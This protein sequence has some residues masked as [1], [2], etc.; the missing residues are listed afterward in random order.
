MAKP[1]TAIGKGGRQARIS[2]QSAHVELACEALHQ[3]LPGIDVGPTDDANE[4][5]VN[6]RVRRLDRT[7][8]AV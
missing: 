8:G 3:R 4:A 7:L 5:P 1:Q 6:G 2:S